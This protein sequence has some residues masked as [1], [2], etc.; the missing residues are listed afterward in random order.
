[1]STIA[2]FSETVFEHVSGSP[3]FTVTAGENWSKTMIKKLNK[4]DPDR[5]KI[6]HIN[7]DGSILAHLPLDCMPIKLKQT[8]NL[9]DSR[10]AELSEHMRKIS[11]NDT[12]ENTSII[13]E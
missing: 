11:K 3:T 9:S 1:M 2:E 8:Y 10:R 12:L 13:E 6:I 4:K 5:V 7:A